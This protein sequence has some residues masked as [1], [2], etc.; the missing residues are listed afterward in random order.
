MKLVCASTSSPCFFSFICASSNL[1][2][3][4]YEG[5]FVLGEKNLE[6]EI[7]G[8]TVL[9]FLLVVYNEQEKSYQKEY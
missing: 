1:S 4:I 2:T 3:E 8:Q 9:L 7:E 5:S 6:V